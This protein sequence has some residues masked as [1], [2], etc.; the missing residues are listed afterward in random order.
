MDSDTLAPLPPGRMLAGLT[1]ARKKGLN[2]LGAPLSHLSGVYMMCVSLFKQ[3]TIVLGPV[4]QHPSGEVGCEIVRSLKL[5]AVTAVPFIQQAIFGANG[6]ELK[7]H[8][9]E[10]DHICSF[11]GNA[12][13]TYQVTG[14]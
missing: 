8:L 3:N 10:L 1:L 7:S 11:G 5:N 12:V 2:Y 4:D 14:C 13:S 6:E 9:M